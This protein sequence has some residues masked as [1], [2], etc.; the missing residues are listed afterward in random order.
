TLK[1]CSVICVPLIYQGNILGLIY[2]GN[3][4]IANLFDQNSLEVI[5]IFA[6]QVTLLLKSA[7]H[8]DRLEKDLD[9]RNLSNIVYT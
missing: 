1:L 6:S 9:I 3:D 2:L 5:T 4:N 7:L 8:I